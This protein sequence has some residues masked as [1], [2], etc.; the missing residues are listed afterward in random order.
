MHKEVLVHKYQDMNLKKIII[1]HTN[2]LKE[3]IT[4]I[5]KTFEN[6]HS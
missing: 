2:N 6:N 4:L 1:H 3:E 5:D